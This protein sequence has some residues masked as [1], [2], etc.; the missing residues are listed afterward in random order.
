MGFVKKAAFITLLFLLGVLSINSAR[1]TAITREPFH[2]GKLLSTWLEDLNSTS[3]HTQDTAKSAIR[4][5]GTNAVPALVRILRANDSPLKLRLLELA[6]KQALLRLYFR[7]AEERHRVAI[8]GCRAL[9]PLA[10]P[11]IP[12]LIGFLNNPDTANEAAYSLAVID[13]GIFPLTR[14][15]TNRNY[16][17]TIRSAAVARLAA[18]QYDEATTVAALLIALQDANP[19]VSSRAARALGRINKEPNLVLP[20]LMESLTNSSSLVRRESAGA[21]GRF[22]PRAQ[23]ALPMLLKASEDS[24]RTVRQEAAAA[25]KAITQTG[26][27]NSR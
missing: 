21:L 15:V 13:E 16:E 18:G 27:A 2:H 25:L 11:A 9:G 10:R 14:A 6:R 8:K 4:E 1:R 26:V 23:S 12:A 3:L 19:E 17:A 24:N 22:G 7:T 20:A 5:M